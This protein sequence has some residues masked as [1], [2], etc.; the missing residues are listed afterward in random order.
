MSC[1]RSAPSQLVEARSDDDDADGGRYWREVIPSLGGEG[2]EMGSGRG[3]AM[4]G[5]VCFGCWWLVGFAFCALVCWAF[6]SVP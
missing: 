6:L 4:V 3:C 1:I 5:G 2:R